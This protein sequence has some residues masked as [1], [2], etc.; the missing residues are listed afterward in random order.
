MVE[1]NNKIRQGKKDT[2]K[3]SKNELL[4]TTDIKIGSLVL[5]IM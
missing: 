3:V 2:M 5:E 4:F 1:L